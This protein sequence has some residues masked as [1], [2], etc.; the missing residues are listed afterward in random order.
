MKRYKGTS[1]SLWF[2]RWN[3]RT[4]NVSKRNPS[5]L[6][7]PITFPSL[8][9]LHC[10]QDLKNFYLFFFHLLCCCAQLQMVGLLLQGCSRPTVWPPSP[11]HSHPLTWAGWHWATSTFFL[12]APPS[13]HGH[14]FPSFKQYS[15]PK[16][17]LRPH[18][19]SPHS[20]PTSL[21]HSAP[22]HGYPHG[23]SPISKPTLWHYLCK[24][25][26]LLPPAYFLLPLIQLF[27]KAAPKA[28][29]SYINYLWFAAD[30]SLKPRPF[31]TNSSITS[32]GL[33][34]HDGCNKMDQRKI[35]PARSH[36]SPSSRQ[37]QPECPVRPQQHW[38][39][40]RNGTLA[41]SHFGPSTEEIQIGYLTEDMLWDDLDTVHQTCA[42]Q[43]ANWQ[44]GQLLQKTTFLAHAFAWLP[45]PT[46]TGISGG[47]SVAEIC[48]ELSISF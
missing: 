11:V 18:R 14:S 48:L 6:C 43:K 3:T 12:G 15:V 7:F 19:M 1:L 31:K 34:A 44:I 36:L 20:V 47:L 42:C 30:K 8:F 46:T 38:D 27:S 10:S 17:Q 16:C 25:S 13:L 37:P 26:M 28:P 29:H 33:Q 23:P 24:H 5:F 2:A 39:T 22:G 40:S 35:P 4:C 9:H 32:F 45:L 41:R 21:A